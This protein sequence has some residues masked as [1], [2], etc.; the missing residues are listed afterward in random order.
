MEGAEG[1][2]AGVG[3]VGSVEQ[4]ILAAAG[5]QPATEQFESADTLL[6]EAP[7]ERH[8]LLWGSS[9]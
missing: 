8:G 1:V 5:F 9:F 6:S 7:S 2:G 3:E 4:P